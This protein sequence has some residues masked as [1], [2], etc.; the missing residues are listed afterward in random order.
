[1]RNVYMY[2]AEQCKFVVRKPKYKSWIVAILA[3]L[4][5]GFIAG[6]FIKITDSTLV[7]IFDY[8]T[9]DLPI[10]SEVWKDS[11][12]KHY[13]ER[14]E[15]YLSEKAPK[16]PIKAEMLTLAAH[17]VYDSTGVLV[18]VEF[19]LA[20][21]QIESSMGTKGKSPVNNPFNVGEY[22]N[23]TVMWFDNTYKGIEAY[24]FLIVKNYL[25]CKSLDMLFKNFTNCN[26]KRYASN[27]DYEAEISKQYYYTQKFIDNRL[28][29]KKNKKKRK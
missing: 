28:E 19:A 14:A 7:Y 17:N 27:P 15:I 29:E 8:Q 6:N 20:Q 2:D 10:G 11:V 1:M 24:Y 18:P 23:G 25:R 3:S 21:A 26:G 4:L 16:S 9:K 13:T 5:I 22:D 12:F